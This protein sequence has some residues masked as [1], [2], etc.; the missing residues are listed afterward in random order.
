MRYKKIL[1]LLLCCVLLMPLLTG[2]TSKKIFVT[3][4]DLYSLTPYSDNELKLETF[5]IKNGARFYETYTPNGFLGGQLTRFSKEEYYWLQKDA[6]LIPSLYKDEIIA[7]SSK[8]ENDLKDLKVSRYYDVGYSIGIYGGSFDNNG[9]YCI[10]LISNTVRDSSAFK[11]LSNSVSEDIRIVEVN[12]KPIDEK[13]LNDGGIFK[14]LKKGDTVEIGYYAGTFYS[15]AIAEADYYFLQSYENLYIEDVKSTKNGYL[16][17]T[18]PSDAKS[19][20]YKIEGGGLF[21]YFAYERGEQEDAK[22]DMNENYF[23]EGIENEY[24]HAQQYSISVGSITHNVGVDITYDPNTAKEEDIS[25]TLVSP[26]GNK[27]TLEYKDGLA[28]IQLAEVI[29]GKWMIYAYPKTLVI[30]NIDVI[31]IAQDPDAKKETYT[32][33]IEENSVNKQFFCY[34]DGEGDIWGTITNEKGEAQ[35]LEDERD[36]ERNEYLATTYGYLEAGTYTMTIYH[37]MDTVVTETGVRTDDSKT[38]DEI[39]FIEE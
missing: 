22:T 5:Y 15:T 12:N 14:G 26:N 13:M 31:P 8:E 30:E 9:Y 24:A 11:A 3:E 36:S 39:I 10:N 28:E 32:F 16:A 37:Y 38:Q 2:C 20:Y 33:E 23:E 34:Y 18:L 21:R 35:I 25:I 7:F 17:V 6:S 27:Y 1:L 19:G 4:E 29:A